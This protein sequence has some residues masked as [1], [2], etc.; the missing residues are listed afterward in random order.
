MH[1]ELA[2]T[3]FVLVGKL[4]ARS[5]LWISL[6]PGAVDLAVGLHMKMLHQF[7]QGCGSIYPF[8]VVK[9]VQEVCVVT[10]HVGELGHSVWFH[11]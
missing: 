4:A 8:S 2:S 5:V 11:N 3:F 10:P 1:Q 7:K 6:A 9:L